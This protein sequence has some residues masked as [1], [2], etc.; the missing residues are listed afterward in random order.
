MIILLIGLLSCSQQSFKDIK[1]KTLE[2]QDKDVLEKNKKVVQDFIDFIYPHMTEFLG[3]FTKPEVIYMKNSKEISEK[4]HERLYGKQ[5]FRQKI[6]RRLLVTD[7]DGVAGYKEFVLNES[8]LKKMENAPLIE[9]LDDLSIEEVN[10]LIYY[11]STLCVIIHEMCHC[12][13][14]E[15]IKG[16]LPHDN[17]DINTILEGHAEWATGNILI[18]VKDLKFKNIEI[19]DII[20]EYNRG[21]YS[22][23]CSDPEEKY[24]YSSYMNEHPMLGRRID[25]GIDIDSYE[26]KYRIKEEKYP[27]NPIYTSGLIIIKNGRNQNEIVK[28]LLTEKES[29]LGE[30]FFDEESHLKHLKK[31]YPNHQYKRFS[32][33]IASFCQNLGIDYNTFDKI[34]QNIED[35]IFLCHYGLFKLIMD[36]SFLI[37]IKTKEKIDELKYLPIYFKKEIARKDEN[38]P[39]YLPKFLKVGLA[40]T[41]NNY[42]YLQN[43]R[44]TCINYLEIWMNG[45]YEKL[46]KDKGIE[47]IEE[48]EIDADFVVIINDNI[49]IAHKNNHLVI[50]SDKNPKKKIF[51]ILEK[52]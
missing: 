9:D 15:N 30:L 18:K 37:T 25:F 28:K 23:Q 10:K 34:L 38:I 36:H 51:E 50:I 46:S 21:Y 3:D 33:I 49:A 26:A 22:E 48:K 32:G 11:L 29:D 39:K 8:L 24:P 42:Y 12:W 14:I 16:D 1:N 44:R 20:E 41:I 43:R 13:Q 7:P 17:K 52:L 35:S 6:G 31:H 19:K 45:R 4:A 40:N 2:Q 27:R 47:K 5:N